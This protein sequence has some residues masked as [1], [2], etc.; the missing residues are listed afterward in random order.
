MVRKLDASTC[1]S[2]LWSTHS[3]QAD[4]RDKEYSRAVDAAALEAADGRVS[5][6]FGVFFALKLYLPDESRLAAL[7]FV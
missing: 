1:L 7:R 2:R 4:A 6:W 3:R 5:L